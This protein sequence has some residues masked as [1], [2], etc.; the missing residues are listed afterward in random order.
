MHE[1]GEL[2][3]EEFALRGLGQA[4]SPV[5]D[6]QPQRPDGQAARDH[7][8]AVDFEVGIEEVFQALGGH[9]VVVIGEA[10]TQ[11]EEGHHAV[12]LRAG[13]QDA[14]DL[15]GG[16]KRIFDVLEHVEADDA[17]EGSVGKR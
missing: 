8:L 2:Q 16:L 4:G 12:E 10:V 9:V 14:G 11:L 6:E 13:L 1:I 17:V 5:H 7:F 15:L 3:V